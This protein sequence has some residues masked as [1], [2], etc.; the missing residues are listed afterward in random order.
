MERAANIAALNDVFRQQPPRYPP[1]ATTTRSNRGLEL[2]HRVP[3][4][5]IVM[6]EP[7]RAAL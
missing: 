2:S 6:R 1:P 5:R 7:P 4:S 3:S